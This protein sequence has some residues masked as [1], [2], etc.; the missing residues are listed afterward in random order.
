MLDQARHLAEEEGQQQRADVGAVDIG[1][2]HDDD[3][4]VAHL[5]EVELL[6]AEA[7][8]DGRDQRADLQVAQH[9]VDARLFDVQDLAAQ[10]QDRLGLAVAPLLGGTAGRVALHD[11][12][13]ALLRIALGAVG[14]LA[15]QRGRI[16]RALAP[17]QLARLARRRAGAGG[18]HRLLDD[19]PR[20]AGILLE[21]GTELVVD[22]GRDDPLDLAVA[23]LGLGLAFEL[24][25]RHLDADD[26]REALADVVAAHALVVLL[27]ELV[28]AG[29]LVDRPRERRAEAAE[30]SAP[31]D[32]VDVVAV[33]VLV[34]RVGVGVLQADLALDALLRS[35]EE[36]D[37]GMHG[38]LV[39]VEVADELD[40]AALEA[41]ALRALAVDVGDRDGDAAV[42]EG[43]LAQAVGQ[44]VPLEGV[45]GED[46]AVRHERD[47]GAGVRRGADLRK[48]GDRRAALEALVVELSVAADL[49]D[50]PLAQG[51]D[52]G[53]ADAVEAAGDLV[54]RAVELA[55]GM[56]RRQ[57]DLDGGALLRR[58]QV[59]GNAA[60]VVR[61]G[62]RAV[63][64]DRDLDM[65]AVASQRLVDRVVD[66]LVDQVVEAPRAGVADVHRGALADRLHAFQDLDVGGRVLGNPGGEVGGRRG[67]GGGGGSG[68]QRRK[69][70]GI[71]HENDVLSKVCESNSL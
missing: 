37:R 43:Q 12:E 58:V 59:D 17:G 28:V 1:V 68:F 3:L 10:R 32:R 61:D 62:A 7:G 54:V 71:A 52:A 63:G 19:A 66:H 45:A 67:E 20:D 55:A 38:R 40:D 70:G 22:D 39:R 50:E 36:D 8:A 21:E 42:Q 24:G 16:E 56:E 53:N 11:V 48:L 5:A 41:E 2:G 33:A 15:G 23:E 18:E 44:D 27:D 30:V 57:D 47:T 65:A 49:D 13:L 29:V 69:R 31:L 35:A 34:L 4:V 6:G 26:G 14:Q 9:A 60:P 25:L 64:V 46:R 51:V